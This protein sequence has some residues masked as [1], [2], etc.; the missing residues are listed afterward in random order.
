MPG[1]LSLPLGLR[2][3]GRHPRAGAPSAALCT[4]LTL[5]TP[6]LRLSRVRLRAAGSLLQVSDLGQDKIY[7][8]AI[9]N[10][11]NSLSEHQVWSSA[12]GAGPRHMVFHPSGDVVYGINEL[13]CTVAAYPYSNGTIGEPTAMIT[14]LPAGYNNQDHTNAKNAEGNPASG[15]NRPDEQTNA[16]ADIHITPDG[17]FLYGSNRGHDSIVCYEVSADGS[18]LTFVA[19]TPTYGEH[20]RNFGIHPSGKWLLAANQDTATVVVFAL[21]PATGALT[22]TG[23]VL[24]VE[25][26]RCVKWASVGSASL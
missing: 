17:K 10:A 15:P 22:A 7:S 1:R 8:Y 25:K 21:D 16:C 12:P 11:S 6:W 24:E 9:D 13:D 26:P 14:T 5:A 20:P 2:G 19:F 4:V 23:D 3:P 18:G